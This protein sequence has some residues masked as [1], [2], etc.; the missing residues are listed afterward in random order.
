MTKDER[1]LVDS[2][3]HCVHQV[4]VMPL[5][6]RQVESTDSPQRDM[7]QVHKHNVDNSERLRSTDHTAS[8]FMT[9]DS[10]G[11]S[12]TDD[13]NTMQGFS[14]LGNAA[15]PGKINFVK[16]SKASDTV[17]TKET[18]KTNPDPS[19]KETSSAKTDN[20]QPSTDANNTNRV[21][22]NETVS[23]TVSQTLVPEAEKKT[24]VEN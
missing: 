17:S 24:Q 5:K 8:A 4:I 11:D 9:E 7:E 18:I 23:N 3:N 19:T 15:K 1:R 16:E 20:L 13:A 21:Q 2:V 22:G 14:F 6:P 10:A 12:R